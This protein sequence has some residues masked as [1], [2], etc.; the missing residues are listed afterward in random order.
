MVNE[1]ILGGLRIAISHNSTLKDAMQSFYNSGYKK[2]EVEE[3][4]KIIH[5]E[6]I[7][8]T[9]PVSNAT[10]TKEIKQPLQK[11]NQSQKTPQPKDTKTKPLTIPI[12]TQK[13]KK[14]SKKKLRTIL[15]LTIAL[16]ILLGTLVGLFI[17]K[18]RLF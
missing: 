18:D 3:A 9:K 6:Q 7:N 5:L 1:T 4:A 15:L 10:Q 2:E 11:L 17:F 13:Q 12:K 16:I 8:Q 14:P